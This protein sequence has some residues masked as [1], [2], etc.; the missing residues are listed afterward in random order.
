MAHSYKAEYPRDS[1]VDPGIVQFFEDF[2]RISDDPTANDDYVGQF[3]DDATFVMASKRAV[4]KEGESLFR[5][6]AGNS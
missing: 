2:Y 1:S 5:F 4:G 3:T 6:G